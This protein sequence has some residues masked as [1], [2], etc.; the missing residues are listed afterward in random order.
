MESIQDIAYFD[1]LLPLV[2]VYP[3]EMT[4]IPLKAYA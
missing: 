2:G 3:E 4:D 1:P